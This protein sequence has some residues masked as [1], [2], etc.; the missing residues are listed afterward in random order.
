MEDKKELF[1]LLCYDCDHNE[2]CEKRDYECPAFD[3][4]YG[5]KITSGLWD[6]AK[7]H[8]TPSGG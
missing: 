2:E 6:E 5:L 4:I 8:L 1:R 7:K 3:L